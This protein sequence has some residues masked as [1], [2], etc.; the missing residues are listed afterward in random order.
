MLRIIAKAYSPPDVCDEDRYAIV[1]ADQGLLDEL[2]HGL[3]ALRQCLTDES[4]RTIKAYGWGTRSPQIVELTE[5]FFDKD[6]DSELMEQLDDYEWALLPR[7]AREGTHYEDTRIEG[8]HRSW[9]VLKQYDKP[10]RES[11]QW[12]FRPKHWD[13]GQWETPDLTKAIVEGFMGKVVPDA[14][15]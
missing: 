1:E 4:L 2:E 8:E 7:W 5:K 13:C 14:V 11:F 12:E 10:D 6:E 3:S 9:C 15:V